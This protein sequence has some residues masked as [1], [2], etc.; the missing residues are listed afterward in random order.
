MDDIA[1]DVDDVD[2]CDDDALVR[3]FVPMLVFE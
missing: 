3:I 1:R 2:D